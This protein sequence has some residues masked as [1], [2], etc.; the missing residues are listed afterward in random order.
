MTAKL[1]KFFQ[2][3]VKILNKNKSAIVA[4]EELM[5][6][7]EEAMSS[8]RELGITDQRVLNEAVSKQLPSSLR[9]FRSLPNKG[10]I[11]QAPLI[12]FQQSATE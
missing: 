12:R 8:L 10:K 4:L 9:K 7:V 1:K 2:A 5:T 11:R 6:V 3:V